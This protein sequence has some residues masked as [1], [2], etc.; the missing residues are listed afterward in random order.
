MKR[1][2]AYK[3]Y[4]VKFMSKLSEQEREDAENPEKRER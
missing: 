4:Y 2:V 1:I 3:G